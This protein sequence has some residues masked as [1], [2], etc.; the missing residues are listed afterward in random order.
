MMILAI[1]ALLAI[2]SL[3][4]GDLVGAALWAATLAAALIIWGVVALVK[5]VKRDLDYYGGVFSDTGY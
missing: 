4:I 3:L 1:P 5:R 2:Y